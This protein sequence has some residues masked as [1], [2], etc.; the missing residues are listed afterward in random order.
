VEKATEFTERMKKIQ[1][2]AG[3]ALRRAQEE[4]K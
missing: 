1:K 3:T 2:E 4:M